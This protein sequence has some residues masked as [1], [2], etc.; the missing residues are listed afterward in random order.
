MHDHG[1]LRAE[2]DMEGVLMSSE[3]MPQTGD[4][5]PRWHFQRTP[6]QAKA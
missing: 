3:V 6:P 2:V 4:Q 5:N 1:V